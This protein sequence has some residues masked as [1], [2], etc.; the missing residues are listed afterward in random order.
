[1]R[2]TWPCRVA[3]RSI[4]APRSAANS[5]SR[6]VTNSLASSGISTS[7][8]AFSSASSA[9]A[10]IAS[11]YIGRCSSLTLEAELGAGGRSAGV[12]RPDREAAGER[13]RSM[14]DGALRSLSEDDSSLTRWGASPVSSVISSANLLFSACSFSRFKRNSPM[15]KSFLSLSSFNC[16]RSASLS[17]TASAFSATKPSARSLC[18]SQCLS[19]SFINSPASASSLSFSL[20]MIVS[21]S[22]SSSL[23]LDS[24]FS[25][26]KSASS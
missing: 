19:A 12:R 5:S 21:R 26:S 17:V 2:E 22:S 10:V 3:T 8:M 6:F 24:I 7:S 18:A 16:W 20:R 9:S 1:M 13:E 11:L 25:S 4:T 23:R 15:S 14:G